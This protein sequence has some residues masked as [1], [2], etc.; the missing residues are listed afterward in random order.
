MTQRRE[1]ESCALDSSSITCRPLLQEICFGYQTKPMHPH[2]HRHD[3][4]QNTPACQSAAARTR[5]A[6]RLPSGSAG[7]MLAPQGQSLS[8]LLSSSPSIHPSILQHQTQLLWITMCSQTSRQT[9]SDLRKLI[10]Q[11]WVTSGYL[12]HLNFLSLCNGPFP[13]M[14][15]GN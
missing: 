7:T 12:L 5:H 10:P 2:P 6:H 4:P 14:A 9:R 3:R 15:L 8:P 11:S 1:S 13:P